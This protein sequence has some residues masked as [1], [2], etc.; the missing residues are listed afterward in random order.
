MVF[1]IFYS[2]FGKTL[3][4]ILGILSQNSVKDSQ[5]ILQGLILDPNPAHEV[6]RS[7][8]KVFVLKP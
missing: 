6:L 1:F 2:N 3:Y 7:Y 8:C 5:A 4:N